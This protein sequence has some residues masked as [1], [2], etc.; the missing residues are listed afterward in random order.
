MHDFFIIERNNELWL[1]CE[2]GERA[3]DLGQRLKTYKLRS[4]IDISVEP[5]ITVYAVLNNPIIRSSDYP[6]PRHM[7]LG[8]RTFAKPENLPEHP[9]ED[10]DKRRI[11]LTIP[12]GSR[13]MTIE[14]STMLEAGI[15][16][17]NGIDFD[18]GCYVGQELTARMHYR[19][20]GKK[21]L[22]TVNDTKIQLLKD[23]EAANM[24][25]YR[26]KNDP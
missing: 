23:T 9:F 19:G 15:D 17:L 1:D 13:D 12:D 24:N 18:K 21:H 7:D 26:F 5:K 4:N 3:E 8:H 2:G 22:Y 10:W 6:D 11:S 25:A 20:L 16:Q 14:K